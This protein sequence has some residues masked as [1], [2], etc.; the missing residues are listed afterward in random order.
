MGR[1]LDQKLKSA[2]SPDQSDPM[3]RFL[4]IPLNLCANR[5]VDR[6]A[7]EAPFSGFR[8]S[9]PCSIECPVS[10]LSYVSIENEETKRRML[11]AL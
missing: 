6:I 3:L 7:G 10:Q 11:T 4:R 9:P 2:E 1:E 8:S 5:P